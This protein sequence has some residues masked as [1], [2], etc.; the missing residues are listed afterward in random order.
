[1]QTNVHYVTLGHAKEAFELVKLQE[2]TK[3]MEYQAEL[4]KIEA[5]IEQSRIEQKKVD[6]EERRKTIQEETRQHQQRAQYQDQL[7]R[8]RLVLHL[9][10]WLLER[11]YFWSLDA[12]RFLTIGFFADTMINYCSNNA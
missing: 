4:K 9:N 3:Q 7:A 6:A 2:T 8:K 10:L 12:Y 11:V 5:H 1:M